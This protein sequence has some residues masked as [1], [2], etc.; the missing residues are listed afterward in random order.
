MKSIKVNTASRKYKI[1]FGE[2]IIGDILSYLKKEFC[3]SNK[4]ILV[5][6]EKVYSIYGKRFDDIFSGETGFSKIILKDGEKNKNIDVLKSI[7]SGLISLNAHRNDIIISLGGGV[8]G[9]T[10]GFAAAT[11]NRGMNLVQIPT[12]IIAQ[13][14]SSIGGKTAINF[15][16]IKNVIGSFYQP[17]LIIID[18]FFLRTLDEKEIINGMGEIIKYGLIFDYQIIKDLVT[19]SRKCRNNEERLYKIINNMKFNDIIYKC[20]KIKSEIV[21]KDESDLKERQLLNFGHTIGHALEKAAGFEKLNHGQ[22][23]ALGM[24]CAVEISLNM[25]LLN[26]DFKNEL[27]NLYELLKLPVWIKN[28][29]QEKI[30]ESLKF[31]KKFYSNINKFILLENINKPVILTNIDEKIIK[32]SIINY[33]R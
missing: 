29:D 10:A 30:F 9:D 14:D 13:T 6:N 33:V 20:A 7:Y 23:V 16:N 31:D 1:L 25:G 4:K 2:N 8:I 32:K 26:K 11:F 24:L 3:G 18:T 21:E 5:S 19:L 12:T 15:E 28:I 17:H 27:I 22:A